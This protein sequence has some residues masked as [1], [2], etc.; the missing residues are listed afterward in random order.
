MP[1]VLPTASPVLPCAGAVRGLPDLTDKESM[2]RPR[3]QGSQSPLSGPP[4]I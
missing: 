2:V 3:S 4:Q 1:W